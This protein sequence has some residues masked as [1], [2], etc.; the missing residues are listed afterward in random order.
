MSG[1]RVRPWVGPC[2]RLP[3][4]QPSA[5]SERRNT[6]TRRHSRDCQRRLALSRVTQPSSGV[7]ATEEGSAHK[8]LHSSQLGSV[9]ARITCRTPERLRQHTR[10]VCTRPRPRAHM[11]PAAHVA[12][13]L[14]RA[15]ERWQATRHGPPARHYSQNARGAVGREAPL[16]LAVGHA[17][18]GEEV[19]EAAARRVPERCV[20]RV[21]AGQWRVSARREG[22]AGG[23]PLQSGCSVIRSV[24]FPT[25]TFRQGRSPIP[26]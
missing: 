23:L 18:V 10:S 7:R 26:T 22:R 1:W 25:R 12:A 19:H 20:C 4:G 21:G 6:T 14:C 13:S 11:R 8:P 16:D 2:G 3:L 17:R 5:A 24:P 15:H 9:S